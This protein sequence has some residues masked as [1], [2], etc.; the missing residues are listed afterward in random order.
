MKK[1]QTQDELTACPYLPESR[2]VLIVKVSHSP[3]LPTSGRR[4]QPHHR[5]LDDII[6]LD[7]TK[8]ESTKTAY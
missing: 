5:R 4:E 3:S 8:K 7:G 1:K 6:R 2:E